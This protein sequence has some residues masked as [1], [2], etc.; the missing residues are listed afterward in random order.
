MIVTT[1]YL[2]ISSFDIE[3]DKEVGEKTTCVTL[4]FN[5]SLSIALL[6]Y[7]V[8]LSMVVSLEYCERQVFSIYTLSLLM[9][10]PVILLVKISKDVHMVR[11]LVSACYFVW[12][13]SITILLLI[14][15]SSPL[16]LFI[17]LLL[18]L[19]VVIV[20]LF[21]AVEEQEKSEI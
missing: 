9:S 1:Y 10:T 15:S 8:S 5:R 2:L 11:K 13:F 6:I 16:V 17:F 21:Y 19:V 14:S 18:I 20:I 3:T 12:S 7:L 4:G